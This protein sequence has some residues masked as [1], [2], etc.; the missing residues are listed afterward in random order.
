MTRETLKEKIDEIF[1]KEL[2]LSRRYFSLKENGGEDILLKKELM[3]DNIK[4]YLVL[5]KV[6]EKLDLLVNDTPL[7]DE[8]ITY[9]ELIDIFYN[10]YLREKRGY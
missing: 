1:V 7:H 5:S 6:E 4:T 10:E 9:G 2:N 8:D 3:M